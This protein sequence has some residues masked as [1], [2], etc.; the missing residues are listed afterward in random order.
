MFGCDPL[1]TSG[2]RS[3]FET[4]PDRRTS[5]TRLAFRL[6]GRL[7]GVQPISA[8]SMRLSIGIVKASSVCNVF[9]ESR[10]GGVGDLGER[11]PS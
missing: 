10:L 5:R 4:D 1:R 6:R 9:D 8:S 7:A 2:L 11:P 3:N